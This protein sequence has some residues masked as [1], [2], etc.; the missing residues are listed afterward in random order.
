MSIF[1]QWWGDVGQT[2]LT[3]CPNVTCGVI[4]QRARYVAWPNFSVLS[5][6]ISREGQ[7]RFRRTPA[8]SLILADVFESWDERTAA[9]CSK[10]WESE[11]NAHNQKPGTLFFR[12]QVFSAGKGRERTR[13][14]NPPRV[15]ARTSGL[16]PL[17]LRRKTPPGHSEQ[18]PDGAQR[19]QNHQLRIRG[20]LSLEALGP[21]CRL[22]TND[23][24]LH[25]EFAS[26]KAYG[27][28]QAD[29][30]SP[31]SWPFS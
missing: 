2:Q 11:E 4:E 9:A 17:C 28:I 5:R 26:T 12:E 27:G 31:D 25:I 7:Q 14:S 20:W 8:P 18:D 24:G 22:P 16:F 1:R 10:T 19:K 21:L 15:T 30:P 3:Q 23:L 29:L 6:G 13:H